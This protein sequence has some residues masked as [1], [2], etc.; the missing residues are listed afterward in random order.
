MQSLTE[1]VIVYSIMEEDHVL[2]DAV[3]STGIDANF[4]IT[5]V[6]CQHINNPHLIENMEKWVI[7][8]G[9]SLTDYMPLGLAVRLQ[10]EP[11]VVELLKCRENKSTRAFQTA[12]IDAEKSAQNNMLQRLGKQ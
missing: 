1:S 11:S 8:D 5:D 2:L 4:R 3:L 10:H 7:D 9:S 6:H 12:V